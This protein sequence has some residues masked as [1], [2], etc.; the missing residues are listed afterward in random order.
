MHAQRRRRRD[1]AP[2]EFAGLADA[3]ARDLNV[4]ASWPPGACC[5]GGGASKET[6]LLSLCWARSPGDAKAMSGG[7][8]IVSGCGQVGSFAGQPEASGCRGYARRA[9]SA[10]RR[11]R[12]GA[13]PSSCPVPS[14]ALPSV[15]LS[16]SCW[17]RAT[18]SI[19]GLLEALRES[20]TGGHHVWRRL[21]S[22]REKKMSPASGRAR[23]PARQA[24]L[25]AAS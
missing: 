25:R 4:E 23:R 21:L 20:A 10:S 8:L 14:A 11:L 15:G 13:Q 12:D 3:H 9:L 2:R 24:R 16:P 1:V 18:R 22:A 6:R 7:R 5:W 17:P 19:T